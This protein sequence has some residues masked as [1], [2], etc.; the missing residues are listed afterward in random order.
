MIKI[1]QKE[2]AMKTTSDSEYVNVYILTKNGNYYNDEGCEYIV[3]KIAEMGEKR[4]IFLK[5]GNTYNQPKH[6][7]KEL[8]ENGD[9][10]IVLSNKQISLIYGEENM[11]AVCAALNDFPD[12]TSWET[13]TKVFIDEK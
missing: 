6:L 5:M 3:D 10:Y 9:A 12:N 4:E 2:I 8:K 7:S 11:K 13:L 1:Y